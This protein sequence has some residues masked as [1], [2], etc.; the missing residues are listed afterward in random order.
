MPADGILE[1]SERDGVD[2][3][4]WRDQGLI[5]ATPGP[6]G[7]V[8]HVAAAIAEKANGAVVGT[9]LV[10]ALR[11]SLDTKGQATTKTVAAVADLVASLAQGVRGAK[12]AAE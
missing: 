4:T 11:D 9:A 8:A 2:Y 6:V 7:D 10:D 12:Q 5:T 1:R 3:A